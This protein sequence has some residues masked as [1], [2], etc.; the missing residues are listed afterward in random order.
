MPVGDFIFVVAMGKVSYL[1]KLEFQSLSIIMDRFDY[2]E[3]NLKS[4]A[5]KKK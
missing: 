1:W 4:G 3:D 5:I 2:I